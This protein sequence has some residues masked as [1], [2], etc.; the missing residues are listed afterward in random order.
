MIPLTDN[1]VRHI[2]V[3]RRRSAA[4]YEI[5]TSGCIDP[6]LVCRRVIV[7]IT[8]RN[9]HAFYSLLV[10]SEDGDPH[11]EAVRLLKE[12]AGDASIVVTRSLSLYQQGK[13]AGALA[14]T[15]SLP[16]EELKKPHAA[17]YHAIFLTAAGESAKAAG[18]LSV[19]Q[20]RRMFPEEKTMLERARLNAT[21]ADEEFC[22]LPN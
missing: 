2:N 10:R 8:L 18:F 19:A 12:N 1:W 21:K 17:L 16:D 22:A 4:K 20:S 9:N 15:G 13:T 11:R 14:L 3:G 7:S 5:G 6:D